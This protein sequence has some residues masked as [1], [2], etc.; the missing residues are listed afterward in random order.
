ME[1]TSLEINKKALA[2]LLDYFKTK[3]NIAIE[4]GVCRSHIDQWYG[5]FRLVPVL[6]ALTIQK[7]TKNKIKAEDLRPDIFILRNIEINC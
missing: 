2:D 1:N 6:K 4:V 3:K 7:L 5:G